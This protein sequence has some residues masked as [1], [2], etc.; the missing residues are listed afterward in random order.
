[1]NEGTQFCPRCGAS[2][3]ETS[4]TT[5]SGAPNE[6]AAKDAGK[7]RCLPSF[8]LGLIGALFGIFGG[9]C[10]T[11]C[12]F[13]GGGNA[14]FLLIFGGSLI[15]L[16]GACLCLNKA[17]IGSII[18]LVSAGMIIYCAYGK[19]GSDFMS[20]IALLLLLA[21]GII[22]AVYSFILKRKK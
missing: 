6:S 1:M 3:E 19:S 9:L 22:G 10:T 13:V 7:I 20:V 17:K 18:E 4:S 12:D 21:G 2:M 15:G 5:G 8:I 14:P 11:M 16:V